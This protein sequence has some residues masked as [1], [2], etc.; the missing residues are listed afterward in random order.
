MQNG[1]MRRKTL[2]YESRATRSLADKRT[3]A[4]FKGHAVRRFPA[5]IQD[6]AR[7]AGAGLTGRPACQAARGSTSR[8]MAARASLPA[9]SRS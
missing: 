8:S 3:A 5:Q 6:R 1:V 4:I 7:D 2:R 9:V